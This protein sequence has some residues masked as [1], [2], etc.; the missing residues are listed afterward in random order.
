MKEN[1]IP[2]EEKRVPLFTPNT[3]NQLLPYG[4]DG[5]VPVLIDGDVTLWDSLAILEYVS[6]K[7]FNGQGWPKD[8]QARAMARSVSA[9]MHASFVN[10]RTHLPMNCKKAGHN[11]LISDDT[12]K[13][14]LRVEK[15]WEDCLSRYGKGQN[16]LFG[17]YSIADAMFAPI[18][19]RFYGYGIPLGD[20]A[21]Q[22][23]NT[24][25]NQDNIKNWIEDGK[26]EKEVIED[27][28]I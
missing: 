4:S 9:E 3:H 11:V 16:W 5:K 28:E 10:I 25:L 17:E 19:I 20:V 7:Y 2:F 12:K 23:V 22:Y 15:I 8:E 27:A 21:T 6:E 13:D 1:Q 14:I 18:A 24:V 26:N